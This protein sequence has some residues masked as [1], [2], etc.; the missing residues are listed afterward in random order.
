MC[1]NAVAVSFF[2]CEPYN[3]HAEVLTMGDSAVSN[4]EGWVR[5]C[6]PCVR[7]DV[8]NWK[9]EVYNLRTRQLVPGA[10]I[11]VKIGNGYALSPSTLVIFTSHRVRPEPGHLPF[12]ARWDF[13]AISEPSWSH[14]PFLPL[15]RDGHY[16]IVAWWLQLFS[17]AALY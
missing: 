17:L 4:A 12:W 2:Q 3:F 16:R 15:N 6:H 5:L 14:C 9:V 10:R 1:T 11:R 13:S 8:G 7:S